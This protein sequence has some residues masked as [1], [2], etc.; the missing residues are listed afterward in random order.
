MSLIPEFELGVWNG[1]ILIVPFLILFLSGQI[2]NKE[3]FKDPP[4]TE[5][6]KKLLPIYIVTMISSFVYPIFLPLKF[7][8]VWFYVGFIVYLVG[9]FFAI[10]AELKFATAQANTLL[11]EGVYRV[12]RNPMYFGGFLIFS[13]IGIACVSW[14][15]L[16]CAMVFIIIHHI[17]LVGPEELFCL[18]KYGNAY[19][20]YMNRTP[21][22][23]GIPKSKN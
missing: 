12:S 16:V 17:L 20:E 2:V 9:G 1:W 15:Y 8:T 5:K 11:T 4:A 14:L 3:K 19:R 23:I 18:E 10:M 13:G 22:W 21:R 6:E 7:G